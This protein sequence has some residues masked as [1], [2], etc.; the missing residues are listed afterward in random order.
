MRKIWILLPVLAI[1]LSLAACNN[2]NSSTG[3]TTKST[4]NTVGTTNSSTDDTSESTAPTVSEQI[5]TTTPATTDP[6]HIHNYS[7]TVTAPTCTDEGFTTYTCTCG[8]SYIS[9]KT[10]AVGHNFGEWK[11][12]KAPTETATGLAERKCAACGETESK[13][14]GKILANHVHDYTGKITS[15]A[16]CIKAGVKTFTCTCGEQYTETIAKTAHNYQT[17]VTTANCTSD[18]YTKYTCSACGDTYTE[19]RV[20]ALGHSCKVNIVYPT[21]TEAGFTEN[22][23]TRCGLIYKDSPISALGHS[24]TDRVTSATC[25]ADGYTTHICVTCSYTY[26]D[27]T[28]KATGH[29]YVFASDTATCTSNGVKIE[30]CTKCN[31]KKTTSTTAFGH[32]TKTERAEPTCRYD[33][34]VKTTCTTCKTVISNTVIPATEDH[35]WETHIVSEYA[36]KRANEGVSGYYQYFAY[37]DWEVDAC[38]KCGYCSMRNMRF[39][40]T[41]YEA[42]MIMLGYVNDLRA[43]VY[44]TH[45]YDLTIDETLIE[46]SKIRSEAIV[47]D[48]SHNGAPL[49]CGENIASGGYGIYDQFVGW[50]NS[51]GHY[52]NMIKK[53]YKYFGYAVN[54][55][56][57][58]TGSAV[59]YGVQ[60]FKY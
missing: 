43:E 56:G 30:K 14:L 20:S 23:C 48:F 27:S 31:D 12:T 32:T 2:S 29:N 3:E 51:S 9:D 38:K 45:D 57:A 55:E 13:T 41:D 25:T 28:T 59:L 15:N 4:S 11:T 42:A 39:R 24:Y 47:E 19:N 17:T 54:N 40:Y 37:T 35:E 34:Y 18:G 44:G 6:P 8:D 5:S 36:Q 53:E 58:G 16:T 7:P 46:W 60:L 49:I 50:K 21:C 33:G 22:I 1:T 26:T 10:A 52:A